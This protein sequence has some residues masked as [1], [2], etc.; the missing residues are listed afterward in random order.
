VE[1]F[2]SELY[3]GP[4]YEEVGD[5]VER[6]ILLDKANQDLGGYAEKEH[7]EEAA[8]VHNPDFGT[9]RDERNGDE[10]RVDSE[11]QVCDCNLNNGHAKALVR[12][13]F[14]DIVRKAAFTLGFADEVLNGQK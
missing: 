3:T 4:T 8:E 9:V 5:I 1:R 7:P 13:H 2:K 12:F 10:D 11:E 14:L 6:W